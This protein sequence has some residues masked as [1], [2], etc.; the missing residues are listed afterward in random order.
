LAQLSRLK[1]SM[2]VAPGIGWFTAAGLANATGLG[3]FLVFALVFLRSVTHL[4]LTTVGTGLT[5]GALIAL[6][7]TMRLG[8]FISRVRLRDLLV[9]AALLR[10]VSFAGFQF[11]RN[12]ISFLILATT[13]TLG[14]RAEQA[15]TPILALTLADPNKQ[16]RSEWLALSRTLFNAGIGGG[17]LIGSALITLGASYTFIGLS[18][19]LCFLLAAL[20]Y[21]QL[22]AGANRAPSPE[23]ARARPW[24]D[25]RFVRLALAG[26][27]MFLAAAILE[28]SL[29][30]YLLDDLRFPGWVVGSYFALNTVLLTILQLPATRRMRR[31]RDS[32]LIL[33]GVLSALPSIGIFALMA[34]HADT[35]LRLTLLLV[36]ALGWTFSELILFQVLITMLAALPREDERSAYFAANQV[37]VGLAIA[38]APTI[39]TWTFAFQPA[40]LFL[41]LDLLIL[42]AFLLIRKISSPRKVL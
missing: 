33:V 23:Q 36:A 1:R 12:W 3:L 14:A 20:C 42:A 18:I 30:V 9:S 11:S 28:S 29:P 2:P 6:L 15:A 37:P 21:F 26:G 22:P 38:I 41:L 7:L 13:A 5:A 39:V 19:S 25:Q 40:T 35:A 27:V 24:S 8:P 31:F 10:C 32:Q 4:A 17:A 16:Q 34:A